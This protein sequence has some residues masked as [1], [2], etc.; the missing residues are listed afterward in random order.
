MNIQNLIICDNK[1]LYDI[2]LELKG[3]LNFQLHFKTRSEIFELQDEKFSNCII[4]TT[5]NIEKIDNQLLID[6]LPYKIIKLV[7]KINIAF[8]KKKFNEQSNIR[9]KNYKINLNSRE[10]ISK[11]KKL[12]LTEKEVTTILYLLNAHK[13]VNV[14]ELQDKVWQ[15]QEE[16]ETHTVETHIHRLRK[17][18][19]ETFGDKN[20]IISKKNGYQI[21]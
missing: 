6:Q 15:Y 10:I 4:L 16:L 3:F 2:F 13:E 1:I 9:T 11:D 5:D 21:D 8:L 18:I 12:K 17:K 20:F 7:E 19:F 14:S